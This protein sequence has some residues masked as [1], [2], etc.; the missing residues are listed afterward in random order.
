MPLEGSSLR[1]LAAI[2]A[3][4]LHALQRLDGALE[5]F[6]AKV[7]DAGWDSAELWASAGVLHGIYN[8]IE[9]SFLRISHTLGDEFERSDRWHAELLHRMFL[10]VPELRPAV[11]PA[12]LRPLLKELLAFRHLYRHGYDLEL[13]GIKL[14]GLIDHWQKERGAV[15]AAFGDFHALLLRQAAGTAER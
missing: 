5:K 14:R 15:F 9:N 2:V 10:D 11:V 13:D 6:G 7:A 3:E 1:V 8:A 4:D 12:R